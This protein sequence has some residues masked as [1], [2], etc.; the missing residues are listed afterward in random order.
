[1]DTNLL[2]WNPKWYRFF[3]SL[4]LWFSTHFHLYTIK[5]CYVP[6]NRYK[7]HILTR[8]LTNCIV[9]FLMQKFCFSSCWWNNNL[10]LSS[11]NK[12]AHVIGCFSFGMLDYFEFLFPVVIILW[13]CTYDKSYFLFYFL[14]I[15][16]IYPNEWILFDVSMVS[17]LE[18]HYICKLF[19]GKNPRFPIGD[20]RS[21][22]GMGMGT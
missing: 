15:V 11:V 19:T 10:D 21:S 5:Q 4:S 12:C 1:M 6:I 14:S 7:C 20:P 8:V 9:L 22:L 3:I 16:W 18:I 2:V 17:R 13:F